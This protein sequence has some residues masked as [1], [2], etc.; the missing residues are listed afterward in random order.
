MLNKTILNKTIPTSIAL[1]IIIIL[2]AVVGAIDYWQYTE[3]QNIKFEVAEIKAPEKKEETV[4]VKVEILKEGSGE[5]AENGNTISV[6]YTGMLEDGTKF[7]S[8]LDR[9]KPFVFTLGVGQVIKGWDLGVLG[10]KVGEKRKLTI[11]SALGYGSTGIS[12]IIPPNAVLIFE[13]ELLSIDE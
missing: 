5:E 7:D 9:E 6:H 10:M 1:T 4:E 12:G 8:S 3:I 11:P 2:A 13:V